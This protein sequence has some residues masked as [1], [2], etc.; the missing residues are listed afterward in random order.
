MGCADDEDDEGEDDEDDEGD[1]GDEGDEEGGEDGGAGLR[2]SGC[3]PSTSLPSH[4]KGTRRDSP[5]PFFLI[6]FSFLLFL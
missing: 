6:S 1:E 2:G 5:F 3:C 4:P